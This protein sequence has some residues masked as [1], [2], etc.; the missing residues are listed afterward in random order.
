ML[1]MANGETLLHI[2][3]K[4]SDLETL[5]ILSELDLHQLDGWQRCAQGKMA[6]DVLRARADFS[7]E[8]AQ[9]FDVLLRAGNQFSSDSAMTPSDSDSDDGDEIWEDA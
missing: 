5:R 9:A 3:A 1:H 6:E 7:E 2:A 8:L 4:H